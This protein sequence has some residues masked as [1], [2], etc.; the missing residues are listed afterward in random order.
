MQS[1]E[2]KDTQGNMKCV[3]VLTIIS[4]SYPLMHACIFVRN[5]HYLFIN[6]EILDEYFWFRLILDRAIFAMLISAVFLFIKVDDASRTAAVSCIV[7]C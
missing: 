7:F 2:W 3:F 6:C 1:C 5:A 4:I